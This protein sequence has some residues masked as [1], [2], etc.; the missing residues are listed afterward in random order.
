MSTWRMLLARDKDIS[1]MVSFYG[2]GQKR[3]DEVFW[4]CNFT[5][6]SCSEMQNKAGEDELKQLP[7]DSAG[8][9]NDI[10]HIQ[11]RKNSAYVWTK[12]E[13]RW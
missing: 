12:T 5:S 3:A 1:A 4:N 13:F 7:I 11:E 8:S 10:W 6:T 9:L 2:F